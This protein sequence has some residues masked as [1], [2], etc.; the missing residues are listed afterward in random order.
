MKLTTKFVLIYLVVTLIVLGVGGYLSYF[1]IQDE[2]NE[3]LKWR[4]LDRI[5]RVTY[6]LEHGEH[7]NTDKIG[8]SG[9]RNLVVRPLPD[10][11][12]SDISVKDTTVWNDRLQ[13]ME[14][15]IK[16]TAHRTVNDTSYYISTHGALA[17]S[18]DI[19][20][21]VIEILLWILAMQIVG[22][23]GVGFMVSNRLFKPFRET[24]KRIRNFK[25][26]EK[27]PIEAEETNV[28][29]FNDLNRF[30]EGMTRKAIRDYENLKQ[31]AENA[32][33]ELKTPLSIVQGK[34]ELLAETDLD[35]D[36]HKY[37]EA[38]SRSI[39]KL[40]KLSSSLGLLTKI[41]N[42]EFEQKEEVNFSELIEQSLDSFRELIKLNGLSIEADI[43]PNVTLHLHPVLA[44]VLWTNL[45][46]NAIKHNV[47]DGH[48]SI[49]LTNERLVIINTGKPL[50]TE[51]EELFK[52]FKKS[53][54][55]AESIGL[56]LSIV[57]RIAQRNNF[58]LKYTFE[59]PEHKI[60]V[61]FRRD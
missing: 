11:V 48:I 24:L 55:S 42:Q 20:N 36:Q 45:F 22:A 49:N 10:I 46:Q 52:R 2:L 58:D 3:E 6:L 35:E 33:H 29:E 54:Q 41:D 28:E 38:S 34:L 7:F 18:D 21:A 57:K 26:Q 39:R 50:S 16:M 61:D 32:S 56:G 53:D 15:N 14:P 13:Q 30:V 23:I 47:D 8:E 37:V 44:D 40:S 25:L 9:G 1:I 17:E 59:E 5:E 60:E 27:E 51:P 31:F 43:N 12:E 19:K 4:F